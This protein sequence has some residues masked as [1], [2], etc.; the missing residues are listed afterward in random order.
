[1]G[2]AI[3]ILERLPALS[4]GCY[5]NWQ[6]VTPNLDAQASRSLVCDHFIATDT[7]YPIVCDFLISEFI[8]IKQVEKYVATEDWIVGATPWLDESI[9]DIEKPLDLVRKFAAYPERINDFEIPLALRFAIHGAIVHCMDR[10]FGDARED[11]REGYD[12]AYDGAVDTVVVYSCT[13]EPLIKR[14]GEHRF[15]CPETQHLPLMIE[16]IGVSDSSERLNSPFGVNDFRELLRD[17][18]SLDRW[19]QQMEARGK[20]VAQLENGQ[21]IRTT[22]WLCIV[23]DDEEFQPQL[24]HLPEDPWGLLNVAPQYPHVVQELLKSIEKP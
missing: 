17:V 24:F 11:V 15:F 12:L 3:I 8:S 16:R 10:L 22:E 6:N 19:K 21:M 4:L 9:D 20:F 1:M 18:A 2:S 5:G 23:G 7:C 14:S 13:G